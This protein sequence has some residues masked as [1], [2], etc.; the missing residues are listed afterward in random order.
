MRK[1][2][3]GPVARGFGT[4][5]L[6]RLSFH[7]WVEALAVPRYGRVRGVPTHARSRWGFNIMQPARP[8]VPGR[9]EQKDPFRDHGA[10]ALAAATG[11][12]RGNWV[13]EHGGGGGD[14]DQRG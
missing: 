10:G 13:S 9:R 3:D 8:G 6:R 4:A 12:R 1:L 2:G 14:D 5:V 11:R 7:R